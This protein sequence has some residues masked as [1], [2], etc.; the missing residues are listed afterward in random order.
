MLAGKASQ[1]IVGSSGPFPRLS[2]FIH[3]HEVQ[4]GMPVNRK[5]DEFVELA[6]G[7]GEG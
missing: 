5:Q 2:I 3:E 7:F 4:R 6:K 1:S